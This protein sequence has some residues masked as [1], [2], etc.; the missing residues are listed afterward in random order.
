MTIL[1]YSKRNILF[2]ERKESAFFPPQSYLSYHSHFDGKG[3]FDDRFV[4]DSWVSHHHPD[5]IQLKSIW[6]LAA[7]RVS[8][9]CVFFAHDLQWLVCIQ[10]VGAFSAEW[11]VFWV[12]MKIAQVLCL[13]VVIVFLF[14]QPFVGWRNC[15]RR[16]I[17]KKKNSV[18]D[19]RRLGQHCSASQTNSLKKWSVKM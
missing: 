16:S 2:Q 10:V 12:K 1:F 4:L 6:N 7:L 19:N 3:S 5:P 11:F 13:L 8:Y 18:G 14:N 15:R 17:T 9:T